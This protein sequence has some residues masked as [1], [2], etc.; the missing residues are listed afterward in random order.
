MARRTHS[1]AASHQRSWLWGRHAVLETLQSAR[2]PVLELLLSEHADPQVQQIVRTYSLDFGVRL[3]EVTS[4][5]IQQL[6]RSGDHQGVAACMGEFPCGDE[7]QLEDWIQQNCINTGSDRF[8]LLV[9]CDRIQDAHNFGAILR[10][11]NAVKADA[12]IVADREQANVTP[13]VARSSAGAVN[14]STLFRVPDL[15]A[16]A[17]VLRNAGITVAA[18]SE[19]AE[20]SCW[21]TSLNRPVALVIGS[22]ATGVHPKLLEQCELQLRIPMMGE[23]QSLNAAVAGGILLYEIR[24]QQSHGSK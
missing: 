8:P 10:C 14:Y 5:R 16:A 24:R 4:D 17:S 12:I 23:I 3:S 9:I 21:Q 2:W 19:K 6:T 11:C 18:A 7:Q 13:H 15:S 20:D 22:E 1:R